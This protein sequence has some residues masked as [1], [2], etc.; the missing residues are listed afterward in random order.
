MS[1][2]ECVCSLVFSSVCG[3]RG[4]EKIEV[5]DFLGGVYFE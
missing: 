2:V 5:G 3:E 4:V 1:L